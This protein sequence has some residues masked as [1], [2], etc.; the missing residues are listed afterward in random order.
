M[1]DEWDEKAR[2][3]A[4]TLLRPQVAR[5]M[6]ATDHLETADNPYWRGQAEDAKA[7]I[8]SVLD[9]INTAAER[10]GIERAAEAARAVQR[11]QNDIAADW[12]SRD[13]RSSHELF[14]NR[15]AGACMAVDAILALAPPSADTG[16]TE[17]AAATAR[18]NE[19]RERVGT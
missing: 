17:P 11:R 6:I 2:E 18:T 3:F 14:S 8:K 7:A 13:L 9:D 10:R 15:A 4:L 16:P 19:Q 1:A 12:A 5:Y